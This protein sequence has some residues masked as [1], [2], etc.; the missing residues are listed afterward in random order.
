[1]IWYGM[2][3]ILFNILVFLAN[4]LIE[5]LKSAF[6]YVDAEPLTNS[7]TSLTGRA[8]EISRKTKNPFESLDYRG[9]PHKSWVHIELFTEIIHLLLNTVY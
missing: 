8:A 2:T 5:I 1:M 7:R 6:H 4:L 3:H 9:K